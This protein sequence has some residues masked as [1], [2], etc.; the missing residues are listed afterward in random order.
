VPGIARRQ[1]YSA[2]FEELMSLASEVF[3][4]LLSRAADVPRNYII[5]QTNVYEVA[6]RRKVQP[7]KQQ[8]FMRR[9]V[10]FVLPDQMLFQR[11][12]KQYQEEGKM[13]PD[14][15]IAEMKG[16]APARPP[17]AQRAC[18]CAHPQ[19]DVRSSGA[20][21][22]ARVTPSSACMHWAVWA[23][24]GSRLCV[25]RM[26]LQRQ[27][28]SCGRANGGSSRD[29][30][31]LPLLGSTI[32]SCAG[33]GSPPCRAVYRVPCPAHQ[34]GVEGGRRCTPAADSE[35]RLCV[36]LPQPTSPSQLWGRTSWA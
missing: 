12:R 36:M 8:G 20:S 24:A 29:V 16:V 34:P 7:F 27:P 30:G 10:V 31:K 14:E 3:T 23:P 9:A 11:Q 6:R 26:S 28:G 13:V 25:R 19:G 17:S 21:S 1:S 5:D 2:R 22:M 33:S 15:T 18:H 4:A 32:S 35:L